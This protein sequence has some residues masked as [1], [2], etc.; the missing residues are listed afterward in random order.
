MMAHPAPLMRAPHPTRGRGETRERPAA[1]IPKTLPMN[2]RMTAAAALLLAL[3]LTALADKEEKMSP[4]DHTVESLAGEKVDLS[5]YKGKVVL[6][7]NVASQC[8]ATPQYGPL[9]ELYEK[10]K[11]EGL[12]V[13]GFPCNQFGS[14]EPGSSQ[15]IAEFCES[16]Y[17]VD[18][19]MMAKVEVNGADASP[20]YKALTEQA[21]DGGPVRWNFEKF[22]VGRDGTVVERFRTGTQPTDKEFVSAVKAELEKK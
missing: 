20:V 9:Q 8:G 15:Q 5:E 1:R 17:Q 3:P 14:Q 2:T 18:F 11:D 16:R 7:V 22:L 12:V 19:P 21:A 13:I 10:H 4:L 6:M